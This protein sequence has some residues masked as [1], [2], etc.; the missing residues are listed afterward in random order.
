MRTAGSKQPVCSRPGAADSGAAQYPH[1]V[2][3][4]DRPYD[5]PAADIASWCTHAPHGRRA[6]YTGNSG[7]DRSPMT[8]LDPSKKQHIH[9]I[10]IAG[11]A[12]APLAGML[13]EH[14][15]RVTGSDAGV[16]PPASTLLDSLGIAYNHSFDAA[17]LARA[18]DLVIVGN[19]I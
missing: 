5:S 16:Y 13:R 17:N 12:M 10:G 18:P 7:A 14:G 15:F 1:R 11:S 9:V 19:I 6:R 4:S 3:R 2:W 8:S